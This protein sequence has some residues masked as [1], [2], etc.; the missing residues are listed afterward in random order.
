MEV[1][2]LKL[3]TENTSGEQAIII[4]K[5]FV[6]ACVFLDASRIEPYIH[7]DQ[8]FDD[9]D[10][11]RF[12]AFLKSQFDSARESGIKRMIIKEGRCEMCVKGHRTSEFYSDGPT[13]RFAYVFEVNNGEIINIFNCNASSGWFKK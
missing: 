13:P 1:I 4:V 5:K 6:E 3:K 11:Y 10:K 12:L 9:L 2:K 8:Y 7:D